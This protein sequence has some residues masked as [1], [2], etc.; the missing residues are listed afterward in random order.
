M[1]NQPTPEF[2]TLR[3]LVSQTETLHAELSTL[4]AATQHLEQIKTRMGDCRDE[5]EARQLLSEMRN[6]E[7]A[8][9]IKQIRGKRIAA[10]LETILAGAETARQAAQ[11]EAGAF[12]RHAP[13]EVASAIKDLVETC[14]HE[15][16]KPRDPRSLDDVIH[17]LVPM[18][19]ANR[20]EEYLRSSIRLYCQEADPISRK[21]EVLQQ[22]VS[23]LHRL[24]D[25]R[26]ELTA[27]TARIVAACAAFRKSYAKH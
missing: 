1:Q 7:E 25:G 21:L 18:A 3:S 24:H 12:L 9:V 5:D 19:V 27:E 11:S 2:D 20:L 15:S 14:R 10:D 16:R 13:Q 4:T 6:A 26:D 17:T 22:S 23:Y 8:V